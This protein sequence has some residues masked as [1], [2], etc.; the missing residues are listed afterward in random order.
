MCC[1]VPLATLDVT[2]ITVYLTGGQTPRVLHT[3]VPL[4][5]AF[6]VKPATPFKEATHK[7]TISASQSVVP[8]SQLFSGNVNACKSQRYVNR[9]FGRL[10][11]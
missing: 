3:T 11:N 1:T 4:P 10:R 8:L 9:I 6:A 5:L 2:V 7:L